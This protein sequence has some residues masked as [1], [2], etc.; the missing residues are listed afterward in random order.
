MKTELK[1]LYLGKLDAQ[2]QTA[3][4]SSLTDNSSKMFSVYTHGIS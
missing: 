2:T 1:M 4:P 3:V